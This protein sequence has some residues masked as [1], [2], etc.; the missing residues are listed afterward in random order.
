MPWW[1]WCFVAPVLLVLTCTPVARVRE[2]SP[3][4]AC[5]FVGLLWSTLFVVLV[6][7]P[8]LLVFDYTFAALCSLELGLLCC[9]ALPGACL[10][11]RSPS[12]GMYDDPDDDEGDKVRP[13][14]GPGYVRPLRQSDLIRRGFPWGLLLS[15]TLWKPRAR[16]LTATGATGAVVLVLA[17]LLLVIRLSSG[18]WVLLVMRSSLSFWAA[19][20][21]L[22][23]IALAVAQVALALLGVRRMRLL[24]PALA[25]PFVRPVAFA[26]LL[27]APLL[28][29]ALALACSTVA[30]WLDSLQGAAALR[31]AADALSG[32]TEATS[33]AM[34]ALGVVRAV[35]VLSWLLQVF[36]VL[37]VLRRPSDERVRLARRCLQPL[38]N[39]QRC[40]WLLWMVGL[41]RPLWETLAPPVPLGEALEVAGASRGEARSRA[42]GA[43]AMILFDEAAGALCGEGPRTLETFAA[44]RP[45]TVAALALVLDMGEEQARELTSAE[46]VRQTSPV[47]WLEVCTILRSKGTTPRELEEKLADVRRALLCSLGKRLRVAADDVWE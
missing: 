44:D 29:V 47:A 26:S 9:C 36:C 6:L 39:T 12:A 20:A 41:L 38:E 46:I 23:G 24:R 33:A 2:A 18:P 43:C 35:A 19:C 17:V 22:V 13:P 14:P 1:A 34:R 11:E 31:L 37:T 5:T 16:A 4:A 42:R 40:Y 21:S 32:G 15:F 45:D 7:S 25:P 10:F 27:A 28:A 8:L 30:A 3:W